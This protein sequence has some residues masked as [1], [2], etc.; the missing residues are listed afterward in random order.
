[1]AG[2]DGGY[3]LGVDLGTSHTVAVL[4]WPD[5]RT[6][7]LLFDGQPIL[8]SGVF[9]D[10]AGRSHVGRDAQRLAQADPARYEPNPKRRIDEPAVLLGDREIAT[11]DLLAG[12]LGAV[13]GA[14]VEAVGFLPPAVLSYPASWGARRRDTLAA[15][16][17]RAGW[18]P[19]TADT[20]GS[21]RPP[22]GTLLVPEPVAAARYF[23]DVL[24]RPVPVRSA[25]AVF[26]FGGGTLDIAV[27]RNE[28][29][30]GNGRARFVVV[31]SGGVA[32]LGGLD[33][34][35]A[36][37]E[38]LG[39]VIRAAHGPI[40]EQLCRPATAS[41]WR[42]RRQFWD[43]VRGAKEM[44]SRATTA[45]VPVPG[46]EQALHLT[47]DELES[48]V[49]PLLRR[50]V[51]EAASVIAGCRLGDDQLAGLF[52]VGG[53]SR[54][55]LVAR[56]LHAELGI[57]PTVLEQPELP[58]AEGALAE[59]PG[60]T[61][62]AA[63]RG[64]AGVPGQIPG[65][66][67]GYEV[68][69][70]M[71]S[72]PP[73]VGGYSGQPGQP[74]APGGP[75][76]P[77]Q[78]VPPSQ[79]LVPGQPVGSGQPAGLVRRR[80]VWIGAGALVALVGVVVATL[81]YLTRDPYPG[82]DFAS[83]REVDRIATREENPS[84]LFTATAGERAYAGYQRTDRRLDIAVLTA[85]SAKVE[86]WITTEVGAERW[87]WIK[88][89]PDVLLVKA[90]VI[91][92][93]TPGDMI[94]FDPAN[95][96]KLWSRQVNGDD[97]IFLFD[98]YVVVLDE[99]A[100]TLVGVDARS[101]RVW[102]LP[103]PKGEYDSDSVVYP[104]RTARHLGGADE[105]TVEATPP[106]PGDEPRLV[107]IGADDSIRVVDVTNGRVLK[108]R[109]AAADT[110][111]KVLA[112]E[113]QLF[114]APSTGGYALAR[115]D[116]ASL[117]APT[118]I[119]NAVDK[120]RR[121]TALEPCGERQVCLLETAGSSGESTELVAVRSDQGGNQQA[122]W[123]RKVPQAQGLLP[124]GER[125]LVRLD[126]SD[127]VAKLFSAEGDEKLSRDGFAVRVDG[128]NLLV[129]AEAPA[130]Y[131]Q[132]ASVAGVVAESGEL[133]ELGQLKQVVPTSCSWNSSVIVCGARS[134]FVVARFVA[135]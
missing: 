90:K 31:G 105:P 65:Q 37:V 24:R 130:P 52:L 15:A 49:T 73:A 23:A 34:D 45:P 110:D 79:P 109:A 42:A 8:P 19:V 132:D 28:G 96:A 27:V 115:Y 134:E 3:G 78:P 76:V 20:D 108:S 121:P 43:D 118:T 5:G 128:G 57:A 35:A 106:N 6:R 30:D 88:A 55:P 74:P 86:R 64:S 100:D 127:P 89:L 72:A 94:A 126:S 36:L 63:A 25:L 124:V 119:Y 122:A 22:G 12:V 71:V 1:M 58:V 16:V 38:H 85:E 40:W 7:P 135:G 129:F 92:S 113:G 10:D 111:D 84:A 21:P 81:L 98:E 29:T 83:F 60:T 75:G 77:G 32:D 53:S 18:P 102:T 9:L 39:G 62:P 11:V 17:A 107:Q 117:G 59:L 133:T 125:V 120:S 33:L 2:Q 61:A 56:M 14:A 114:V 13:A 47:R 131:N 67:R 68:G 97:G 26:D 93:G 123:R 101:G 51:F 87:D 80:A 44:L 116:L 66:I 103:N 82:L 70:A 50:G 48:V 91:G 112:Y 99:T 4:R 95:G 41:Q 54:V 46:V 69:A 104:V